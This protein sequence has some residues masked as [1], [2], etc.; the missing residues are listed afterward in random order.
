MISTGAPMHATTAVRS[1]LPETPLLNLKHQERAPPD[2]AAEGAEA[3]RKAR[4]NAQAKG[5]MA[6]LTGERLRPSK[7]AAVHRRG[8]ARRLDTGCGGAESLR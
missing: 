8:K 4:S 3:T 1:G 6:Y 2:G 7:E 5:L